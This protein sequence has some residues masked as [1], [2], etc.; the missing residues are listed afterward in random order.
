MTENPR[1]VKIKIQTESKEIVLSSEDVISF[2]S[3]T[4]TNTAK[5]TFYNL[6]EEQRQVLIDMH[7]PILQVARPFYTLMTLPVGVNDVNKQLIAWNL[8]KNTLLAEDNFKT[9]D[10][11]T[12][13]CSL[14]SRWE[15]EL[16]L[17]TFN[18]MPVTRVFDYKE[19]SNLSY[20]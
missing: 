6:Q 7:D 1:A 9:A 10:G 4:Q 15:N 18:N 3:A 13:K 16:I 12:H 19:K 11:C 2:I 5:S 14:Q 17:Q 20:T 8:I